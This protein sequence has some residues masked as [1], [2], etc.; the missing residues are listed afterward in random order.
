VLGP[1]INLQRTPLGGRHFEALS[2]DPLLTA[3]LAAAYV[4]GVQEQGVGATAKHYVA[5]DAESDRFTVDNRVDERTL[6]EVYLAPFETAVVRA[7]SWLV[8]SAYNAVNGAT[9]SEN[10]LLRRPLADEWGFDGVVVSDWTA[11]RSTEAA[12]SAAQDL[13][14]PGPN[15]LWARPLVEAVRAGRVPES[16]IDEKVERLLR[17]A[18]RVGALDGVEPAVVAPPP[19]EDGP[20]LAREVAAA[21]TVLLRNSGEL[22]W[23]A[24]RLRSV[25]VLGH[26]AAAAPRRCRRP[27]CGRSCHRWPGSARPSGTGWTSGSGS[28][29]GSA[30]P[31]SRWTRAR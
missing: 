20:A 14:M 22:P 2:E 15:P 10:P 31:C 24:G 30:R 26:N 21:G 13:V 9:M 25:A 18:A 8:M 12:A 27:G 28:A 17:L 19:A 1:T 7:G 29:P 5:N 11:V 23:D 4:S 3:R 16:A 6:R